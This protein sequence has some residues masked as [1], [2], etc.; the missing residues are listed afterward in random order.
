M[1]ILG[2]S[3]GLISAAFATDTITR[4][5]YFS[6]FALGLLILSVLLLLPE[7]L[8]VVS[9]PIHAI[10][11]SVFFPRA[12]SP[13][14]GLDYFRRLI[15]SFRAQERWDDLADICEEML[16]SYPAEPIPYLELVKIYGDS[17]EDARELARIWRKAR[18]H[19]SE[20]DL[21][22]LEADVEPQPEPSEHPN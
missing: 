14:P 17:S 6:L 9:A 7:A 8:T 10:A 16:R 22:Q 15:D 5:F 3:W 20:H 12:Q 11:D 1:I 18:K 21:Q 13:K 19:L 2:V 4:S